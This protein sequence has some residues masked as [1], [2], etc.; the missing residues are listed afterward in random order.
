MIKNILTTTLMALLLLTSCIK[1]ELP[2]VEADIVAVEFPSS[3]EEDILISKIERDRVSIFITPGSIDLTNLEITYILSEGSTIISGLDNNDYSSPHEITV[4]SEDKEWEK[5]YTVTVLDMNIPTTYLFNNWETSSYDECFEYVKVGDSGLDWVQQF[6][7]ASGNL[8]YKVA[9]P[10]SSPSDYPTYKTVDREEGDYAVAL[11][12]RFI[13]SIGQGSP[14]AAGSLFIGEFSSVGIN[15]MAEPM[16]ATRFGLPFSQKPTKMTFWFKYDAQNPMHTY[17][18]DGDVTGAYSD[19]YIE[20]NF[21]GN[22]NVSSTDDYCAIYA[23]IYDNVKAA[24]L[25]DGKKYLDGSTILSSEAIVGLADFRD[26]LD[27]TQF[28]TT[29]EYGEAYIYKEVEFDY[30]TNI[31][32]PERLENYE[33]SLAVVFSSSYNGASFIGGLDNKLYID[34]VNIECE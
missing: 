5:T 17:N 8:G 19:P 7:W 1:D 29:K 2:N 27:A 14:I 34:N 20:A 26:N 3:V 6:I 12:T 25:Y 24:E 4:Q 32:D 15:I 30:G 28:G 10:S 21:A 9:K 11:V 18:S 22:P 16:K 33:Y 13:G 23:V 31:I